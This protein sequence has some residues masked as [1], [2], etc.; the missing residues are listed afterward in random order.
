[1]TEAAKF[2]GTH[3]VKCALQH[4]TCPRSA[5]PFIEGRG[6]ESPCQEPV[7]A[8]EVLLLMIARNLLKHFRGVQR[9]LWS[10]ILFRWLPGASQQGAT[11]CCT[12]SAS[13][14]LQGLEKP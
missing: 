7:N 1:M 4:E 6:T 5:E 13:A 11:A 9:A 14:P 3:L 12:T 10:C 2:P 8:A